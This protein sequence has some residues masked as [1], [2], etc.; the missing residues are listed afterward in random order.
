MKTED[1]KEN[2]CDTCVN[3]SDFPKCLSEFGDEIKYGDGV[4][5]NNIIECP[6][7]NK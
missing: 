2:L 7:Y 4:G 1:S 3:Q 5:N 6:G